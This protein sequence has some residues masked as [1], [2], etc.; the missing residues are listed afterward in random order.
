MNTRDTLFFP[1]HPSTPDPIIQD[2]GEG[3][4][5][6]PRTCSFG[7]GQIRRYSIAPASTAHLETTAST[8]LRGTHTC[9]RHRGQTS[10]GECTLCP[11]GVHGGT[12]GRK[13]VKPSAVPSTAILALRCLSRTPLPGLA[14]LQV[15]GSREEHSVAQLLNT[16][17]NTP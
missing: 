16:T 9:A 3:A 4:P 2:R 15:K 17:T 8:T 7:T 10:A 14:K 5:G 11:T 12:H 1:K 6:A 13:H